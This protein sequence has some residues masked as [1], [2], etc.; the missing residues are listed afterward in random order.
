[1]S[2]KSAEEAFDFLRGY[3]TEFRAPT[4][5]LLRNILLDALAKP[6]A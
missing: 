4:L 6:I 3:D 2:N 1:L 5:G